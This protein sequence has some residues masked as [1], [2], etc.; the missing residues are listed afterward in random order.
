MVIVAGL[1]EL[2][3]NT[4]IKEIDLWQYPLR[5]FNV[6]KHYMVPI[7]GIASQKIIERKSLEDVINENKEFMV[8]FVTEGGEHDLENFI[9]PEN[10]LYIFGK[11]NYS[12]FN[13]MK[14]GNS[15]SLKIKT[16]QNKGMLWGHQ[17]A[18]IV[19]YDRMIKNE[20]NNKR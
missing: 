2:I 16:A 14:I 12:P 8:I 17:A 3:W 20:C 13:T 4:P 6:N 5:D 18:S 19:L 10:G 7:S 1:W 11:T 9:H 15:T